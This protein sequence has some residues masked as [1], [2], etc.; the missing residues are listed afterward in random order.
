MVKE[1]LERLDDDAPVF[2]LVGPVLMRQDLDEAK[3]NVDKRVEFIRTEMYVRSRLSASR[4]T[5]H[6]APLYLYLSSIL[7][8]LVF[9][10]IYMCPCATAPKPRRKSKRTKSGCKGTEKR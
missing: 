9:Q 5:Q 2:K 8:P 1:E 7:F 6:K 10:I 4:L 3:Q